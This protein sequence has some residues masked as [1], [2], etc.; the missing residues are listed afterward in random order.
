MENKVVYKPIIKKF[1]G[2][3]VRVVQVDKRKEY[4]ICK[5]IF[6][7]LGLV[8][9]NGSWASPKKKMLDFLNGINKTPAV[10]TLDVRLKD[11]QSKK[12][13]IR[14]V[15]CINI[16][17]VP[18]ILTQFQPTKRRSK[19]ILERWYKFMKFVDMLLEYHEC[20]KYIIDDKER[21][22]ITMKEIKDN[23]G[24][25]QRVNVMIAEIMGKLITGEDNFPIKKDELK[26]YQPQTTIDLLE[27]RNF[28]LDKFST[29]YVLTG[30]H[31]KARDLTLKLAQKKYFNE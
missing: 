20:H 8:K 11:K 10:Q 7:V 19:E 27:V 1:L 2:Y 17:V 14:E 31:D 5:D 3:N 26:I 30:H 18:I 6:D 29:C 12:G 24:I 22:K 28:V 23:G 21:Y 16:E 9:E 13:Q 25:P 4:I 15:D